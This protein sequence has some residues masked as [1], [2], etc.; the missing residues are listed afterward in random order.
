MSVDRD[1][2]DT[3]EELDESLQEV[4]AA[5][6][7]IECVIGPSNI[8]VSGTP[9]G[10]TLFGE[11]QLDGCSPDAAISA[12]KTEFEHSK[13]VDVDVSEPL[14]ETETVEIIA[15]SLND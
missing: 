8:I 3:T 11:A 10:D 12:I 5:I 15:T 2:Q 4:V 14:G 9:S 1:S 7:Q 6:E 13:D